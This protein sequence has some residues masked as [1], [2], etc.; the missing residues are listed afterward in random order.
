MPQSDRPSD[1][2]QLQ[3]KPKCGKRHKAGHPWIF[4]NE[5]TGW[6][7]GCESG[8]IFELL[9]SGGERRGVGY[10][11]RHTLI[12]YR[13][14]DRP[15][16]VIDAR[17]V[18][19]RI[20]RAE[21]YRQRLLP[22]R[23]TYRLIHTEA[24]GFPGLVV[25]RYGDVFTL[26]S[27]TAGVD[28]LLPDVVTALKDIYSPRAIVEKSDSAFR[29]LEEVPKQVRVLH[30][31]LPEPFLLE[32]EG[33]VMEVDLLGGQKTG[34]FLDQESNRRQTAPLCAGGS[35]LDVCCYAGAW[36]IHAARAGAESV[37]G[38]DISGKAVDLARRNAEHN[39]VSNRCR[40]EA[41]DAFKLLP[42]LHKRHQKFEVVILDPPAFA[43]SKRDVP[44]ALKGY[45]EMNRRGF[46]LVSRGGFLVTCSCSHHIGPGDFLDVVRQAGRD[47]GRRVRLVDVRGAA[48][49]HPVHPACPES[50]YLTCVIAAV[51]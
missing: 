5:L 17:W 11:N 13:Q 3:L 51:E 8:E 4:S 23:S 1:Y 14:L 45:R 46:R 49:D 29:E 18:R 27:S 47:L 40:F 42:D 37:L 20:E 22:G 6:P 24:D 44:A 7:E 2:P 21:T 50:E 35:V 26:S 48:P 43:K 36:S 19:D 16:C 38:I 28:R 25:E 31:E 33:M 32:E 12:A 39:D 30:G 15:G 41:A 9:D 10:A 34:L